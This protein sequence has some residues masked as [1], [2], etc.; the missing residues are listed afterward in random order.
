MK[1]SLRSKMIAFF[2]ASVVVAALG[3]GLI[4]I[5]LHTLSTEIQ[6]FYEKDFPEF[7]K[8]YVFKP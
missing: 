6:N 7:K 8:T 1:Q 4:W 3:F 5:N 2:M